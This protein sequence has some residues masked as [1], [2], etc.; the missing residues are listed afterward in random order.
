MSSRIFDLSISVPCR[1]NQAGEAATQ[2]VIAA[3]KQMHALLAM[4]AWQ[5]NPRVVL[6]YTTI[7]GLVELEILGEQPSSDEVIQK[8]DSF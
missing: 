5:G 2:I 7:Q 6:S 8:S 1:D 4:L 3:A